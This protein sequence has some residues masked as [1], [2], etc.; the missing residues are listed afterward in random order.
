M[1]K[2]LMQLK[3]V[4]LSRLGINL[5]GFIALCSL[6]W[7]I[8]YLFHLSI[9]WRLIFIGIV[10]LLFAIGLLLR[11]IWVKRRGAKLAKQLQVQTES[12]AGRQMEVKIL[13]EKLNEAINSLKTSELGV[14]YRGNAALYALP[15]Y[16]VIGPAA[17]GKS[18]LLRNSGLHFPFS[19]TEDLQIKGFGG[20]KNC[21]WW[22]ADEA[23]VLD[24]AGRYTTE[25]NDRG[26]W[27]AF[28]DLL[29]KN[30]PHLPINGI[31]VAVSLAD[32]LTGSADQI[33]WH[34]KV[35]RERVEDLY[36]RLGFIFPVTL[37]FT[38][39]DL[40]KGFVE[41]FGDL[42]LAERNQ[43]WGVNFAADHGEQLD[44]L[45]LKLTQLR[46]HKLSMERNLQ[47][48]YTIYD[49]PEQFR[50]SLVRVKQLISLLL[51][52]NPYQET[53][54]FCGAYF[55]SGT[56]EGA[57]MQQLIGNLKTAFGVVDAEEENP[58]IEKKSYFIRELFDK[59]IIP[60]KNAIAKTKKRIHLQLWLKSAAV[61]GCIG[62]LG[63]AFLMLIT[64]FT[65]NIM[66]LHK[67]ETL[68]QR[69]LSDESLGAIE[70]SYNYYHTLLNYKEDVPWHLRLGLYRGDTQLPI[71]SEMLA[72]V[73][74]YKFAMPLHNYLTNQLQNYH[75]LWQ[76]SDSKTREQ[77]RGDYYAA[78]K[79]YLM[80]SFPNHIDA[81]QATKLFTKYWNK[82]L[83]GKE[84]NTKQYQGVVHFYVAHATAMPAN[85]G[86]VQEARHD[87]YL[88]NSAKNLYTQLDTIY[89][90]ELASV[91]L[92]N[93][94]KGHADNLLS[95]SYQV[96][97]LYT[98]QGWIKVAQPVIAKIAHAARHKDW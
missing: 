43:I 72:H 89:G 32:L 42:S 67:G 23:V 68:A 7:L 61:I 87:L 65:S 82:M 4:L 10:I 55:T 21:D 38:K 93:L 77:L 66:L 71:M 27:L 50:A 96:P 49:F 16:M 25:D 14:K 81:D 20:T 40:L 41:F 79:S 59:V 75:K 60:N 28:L 62:V 63:L 74:H 29:Q 19:S 76:H 95:S 39:V 52:T 37:L 84:A 24:T 88:K 69:L 83:F 22:F 80:L 1:Y 73:L 57:P 17:G 18:T 6:V 90:N 78:L 70:D 97:G 44:N 26:E 9:V 31:I 54:N 13:G 64:S 2:I 51:K 85:K 5:I 46:L 98:K 56:Q 12:A 45:Y 11:W 8:G 30:R 36:G 33:N 15:W 53:P 94:L 91:T 34:V 48:K 3:T 47:R 35:I 58:V 92:D 86:M